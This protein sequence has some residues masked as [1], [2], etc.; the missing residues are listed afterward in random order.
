VEFKITL[1][2]IPGALAKCATFLANYNI[3]L[4]ASESRTIQ[5]GEIAEWIVVAD[6]SKCK[7][8]IRNL[9]KKIVEEGFAKNSVCRSFQ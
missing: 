9:C 5:Q 3:N 2:D 8:N 1:A 6:I 7:T 4:V